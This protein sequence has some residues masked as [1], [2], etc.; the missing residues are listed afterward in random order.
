MKRGFI[1]FKGG[2]EYPLPRWIVFLALVY[3]GL[4][5]DTP[6]R[7]VAQDPCEDQR[8]LTFNCQ[9]DSFSPA[10]GG[11]VP[12]GWWPFV[13]SGRPA[14][15]Q[16]SDTPKPPSLRIWSDGEPFVAG[17]Y[18]EISGIEPGATYEAF[19]GWAVF[20][21]SGAEMGRAIGIDPGGGTDATAS[22]VIWSQEVW[23]KKR[24]NPELRVR[25]VAEAAKITVFVRINHPRSYGADQA[26]LDAVTLMRDD[27]VPIVNV[28]TP[29]PLPTDTPSLTPTVTSTFMATP[30]PSSTPVPTNT[31]VPTS[32]TIATATEE[33]PT[34]TATSTATMTVTAWP[35]GTPTA[36]ATVTATGSAPT[37]WDLR[38]NAAEGVAEL[39]LAPIPQAALDAA[40]ESSS[41][42]TGWVLMVARPS[43]PAFALL[44]IVG[45]L[46]VIAIRHI[47]SGG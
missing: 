42:I 31:D 44:A 43:W 20:Q 5:L 29:T 24:S 2:R 40:S 9:F 13:I 1:V 8:N 26:F 23:E 16:A 34:A 19:I 17:I 33:A 22:S 11:T 36:K 7:A 30:P 18:Q 38:G 32:T 12:Q 46:G 21:S 47:R 27:S 10:P 4:G 25:V 45:L 15:D 35:T 6:L 39:A 14:F 41:G 37:T 28:A 3:L